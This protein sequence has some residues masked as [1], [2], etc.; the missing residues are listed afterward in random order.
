MKLAGYLGVIT[1]SSLLKVLPLENV[2]GE[3]IVGKIMMDLLKYKKLKS[4]Y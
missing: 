1:K 4:N 2:S 3:N